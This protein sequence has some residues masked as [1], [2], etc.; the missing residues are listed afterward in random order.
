MQRN[1]KIYLIKYRSSNYDYIQQKGIRMADT[2]DFMEHKIDIEKIARFRACGTGHVSSPLAMRL[3]RLGMEV[4]QKTRKQLI[5][6]S[7]NISEDMKRTASWVRTMGK[8]ARATTHDWESKHYWVQVN[9]WAEKRIRGWEL[10]ADPDAGFTP[11]W[12]SKSNIEKAAIIAAHAY[13]SRAG[14]CH[15]N[16]SVA[17][18]IFYECVSKNP[19]FKSALEKGALSLFWIFLPTPYNHVFIQLEMRSQDSDGKEFAEKVFVD[20]WLPPGFTFTSQEFSDIKKQM[21][22]T[23]LDA[24]ILD[25]YLEPESTKADKYYRIPF[26]QHQASLSPES[27]EPEGTTLKNK[28]DFDLFERIFQ[29]ELRR[30]ELVN[31][32]HFKKDILEAIDIKDTKKISAMLQQGIFLLD[33]EI[34]DKSLQSHDKQVIEKILS[35]QLSS[36]IYFLGERQDVLSQKDIFT[37]DSTHKMFIVKDGNSFNLVRIG[38]EGLN[39]IPIK[40]SQDGITIGDRT[41]GSVELINFDKI[42]AE[43]CLKK[44]CIPVD[45]NKASM[46]IAESHEKL[47][48][49][50]PKF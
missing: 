4:V 33:K 36:S 38:P 2:K 18:H 9:A 15:E 34:L 26:Y 19:E 5:F 27:F 21:V 32:A 13:H 23:L 24:V 48:T 7:P 35:Y 1:I 42:F 17:T 11:D 30:I 25:N 22:D 45:I 14:K 6:G 12:I 46:M 39:E 29:R 44:D 31:P 20:P 47:K 28:Y 40:F 8:I 50:G 3:K 37:F 16:V 43:Y 10:R 41:F 49:S